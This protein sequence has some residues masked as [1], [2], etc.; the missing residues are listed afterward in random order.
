MDQETTWKV[1]GNEIDFKEG[2]SHSLRE[3][4]KKKEGEKIVSVHFYSIIKSLKK[5]AYLKSETLIN[6]SAQAIIKLVFFFLSRK[7]PFR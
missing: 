3:E 5:R 4:K 7:Y 1:C 2:N 6:H